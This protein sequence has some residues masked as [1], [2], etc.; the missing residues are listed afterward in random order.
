VV[1]VFLFVLSAVQWGSPGL[2]GPARA[3]A[4]AFHP[5][6]R[7]LSVHPAASPLSSI[8]R[9]GLNA[10]PGAICND[11]SSDC[12]LGVSQ[13]TVTMVVRAGTRGQNAWPAIQVVFLLETT[14]YDG[15]YDPSAEVPGAD[16][17]GDTEV[18][19]APLCDESNGVPFFV[20]YAGTIAQTIQAENA[21]SSYSFALIDYYATHDIWDAGGGAV[22][23][24]DVGK[25][26]N[27]ST[28]G[29][30]VVRDFQDPALGGGFVIPHS[31][32]NDNFLDSSS[33]SALY[34]ALSGWGGINWSSTTHHVLVQIGSTAPR[35]PGYPEDYCVS[36]AVTP[37]GLG[38]CTASTCEPSIT[39]GQNVSPGC[40]GWVASQNENRSESIAAYAHV[41]QNCVDSLGG[42]CTI[43]EIDLN[44]TPTNPNSPSWSASGGSGG[45]VNWT[46]DAL[47]IVQAGCDMAAATNGTWAGPTW[48]TCS[49]LHA[50]GTLPYVPIVSADEPTTSN[51][52]LL[53]ALTH[54][55]VGTVPN[56]VVAAGTSVPLFQFVPWGLFA[57][58]PIPDWSVVCTNATGA[59]MGCPS[60]PT[61]VTVE[62]VPTFGWNWSNNPAKNE[63]HLGDIW[64]VSFQVFAEGP[65]YGYLPVDACIT[66]ACVKAGSGAIG[67]SYTSTTFLAYGS[68]TTV[69][70][71]FPLAIVQLVPLNGYAVPVPTAPP[72]L[73]GS[74]PPPVPNPPVPPGT[75]TAAAPIPASLV[76]MEA[77][78]SGFIA[79]GFIRLGIRRPGV[80]QRQASMTGP[81]AMF[82]RNRKRTTSV[83]RWT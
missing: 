38:N 35:D 10:T 18:G 13:S 9:L 26:V 57:P 76:P 30:A 19:E 45:P 60:A 75:P 74:P 55:G 42:N 5:E 46:T 81:A 48:F 51:P 17:C 77:A 22:Y 28:F 67:P 14:P 52:K 20:T 65:P 61:E 40:E 56:P 7:T 3:D 43:D 32:L 64:E 41:A 78:A 68:E 33:I 25:F 36:P 31:D 12:P 44:D 83:G 47:N 79:A 49:S 15:V 39:F 69:T 80:S 29:T 70:Y 62:S 4:P 21:N 16:P 2:S 11:D 54:F 24:V 50:R 37:K 6:L 53:Q 58:A 34:A 63:M 59:K 23:H 73:G 82:E 1:G 66:S 8:V 27:A 72:K 71:S